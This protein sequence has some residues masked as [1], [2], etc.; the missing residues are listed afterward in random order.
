MLQGYRL[1][2]EGVA[3]MSRTFVTEDTTTRI[4]V[5]HQ[6]KVAFEREVDF[7]GDVVRLRKARED[8]TAFAEMLK[9]HP[10]PLREDP[11]YGT[12]VICKGTR[13]ALYLAPTDLPGT[14][15]ACVDCVPGLPGP[16]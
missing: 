8:A 5:Y 7:F 16:R 15:L 4:R 1:R 2:E 9:K 14:P 3:A 6:G 13:S 10:A 12:C 11:P